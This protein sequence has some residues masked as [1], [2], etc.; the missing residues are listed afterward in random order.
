MAMKWVLVVCFALFTDVTGFGFKFPTSIND[1][2][3][4]PDPDLMFCAQIAIGIEQ[5]ASLY[6]FPYCNKT[7][8][9]LQQCTDN[10][11]ESLPKCKLPLIS[12]A[13]AYKA[14]MYKMSDDALCKTGLKPKFEKDKSCWGLA[15]TAMIQIS[16][17]PPGYMTDDGCKTNKLNQDIFIG[18]GYAIPNCAANMKSYLGPLFAKSGCGY[19]QTV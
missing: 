8:S 7:K 10:Y 1:I 4:K 15:K 17:L 16:N 12:N 14:E 3:N 18:F 9:Q 5:C 13:V 11:I 6:D 2:Y 19:V